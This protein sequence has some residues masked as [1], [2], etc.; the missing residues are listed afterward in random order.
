MKILQINK[1]FYIKGG[2]ERHLFDLVK[3]LRQKNHEVAVFSTK[4]SENITSGYEKYF[5][6][7]LDL[8]K[9]T[10]SKCEIIKRFFYSEEAKKNLDKLLAKRKID[11]AHVHNIYHHLSPSI[12]SVLKK[13]KIPV[14]MTLHDYKLIC[15]NYHLLRKGKFCTKCL[16]GKF[17]HCFFNKCVRESYKASLVCALEGYFH[18]FWGVYKKSVDVFIAPSSFM[19]KMMVKAGFSASN[20]EVLPNFIDN[21]DFMPRYGGD[22]YI[23]Y[24]GRLSKEKGVDV[25]LKAMETIPNIRLLV[26]G[27]GP[28]EKNIKKFIKE[29]KLGNIKLIGHLTKKELIPHIQNAR[30]SVVPSI[31]PEVCPLAVLESFALGKPVIASNIGGLPELVKE[32]YRGFLFEPGNAKEL[33][34]KIKQ[35]FFNSLLIE[36]MG[37]LA[38]RKI[39]QEHTPQQYYAKLLD[40]YNRLC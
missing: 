37:R 3:L 36:K 11:I 1:F 12:I 14:V 39:D 15:P 38:R 35:L 29:R 22:R 26:I 2:A 7:E 13:K 40:V 31:W 5:V 24:F 10:Q 32:G 9:P 19:K 30:F 20:I 18:R 34:K 33:A 21:K 6:S 17:Y 23:I 25:L 28:E 27:S 8:E 16:G 4:N